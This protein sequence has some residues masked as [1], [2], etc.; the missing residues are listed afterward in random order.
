M[1]HLTCPLRSQAV[2]LMAPEQCY[3]VAPHWPPRLRE[4]R[5]S[6]ICQ[7]P[8]PD[9]SG[10]ERQMIDQEGPRRANLTHPQARDP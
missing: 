7:I 2:M 10:G 8:L 1:H 6:E 9:Q 5:D 4:C 3:D